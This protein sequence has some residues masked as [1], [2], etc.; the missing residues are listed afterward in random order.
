MTVK[1]VLQLTSLYV[2]WS[3]IKLVSFLNRLSQRQRLWVLICMLVLFAAIDIW[4]LYRGCT[5]A[6]QI[7]HIEPIKK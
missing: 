1:R 4:Q 6:V 3:R 5:K 2:R 7:E